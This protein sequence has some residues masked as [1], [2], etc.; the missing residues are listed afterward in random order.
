MLLFR[1]FLGVLGVSG[2]PVPR[3]AHGAQGHNHSI[4]PMS[5]DKLQT[6]ATDTTRGPASAAG[7]GSITQQIHAAA[8]SADD[9]FG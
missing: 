2:T 7:S 1:G 5:D 4:A 8:M 6:G 3:T 9:R